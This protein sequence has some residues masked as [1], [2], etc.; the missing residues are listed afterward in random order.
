MVEHIYRYSEAA[1]LPGKAEVVLSQSR[2]L[3]LG[4]E[5]RAGP[6]L[7]LMPGDLQWLQV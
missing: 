2:R 6:L 5:A 3:R 7:D 4:T 1:I